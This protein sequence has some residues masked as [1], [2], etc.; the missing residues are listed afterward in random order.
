MAKRD[1]YEILGVEKNAGDSE[2]KSNYRKMAM[3]YHPDKNPGDAEA[4]EKF[5]EAAEA[6][7]VLSNPEKRARYDRFGH[8][9]MR[10]QDYG[11]YSNVNDIFS[12]FSDIFGGGIFDDFFGG[13]GGQRGGRRRSMAEQGSDLRIKLPLTLEEISKGVEKTIKIKRYDTCNTCN[14]TGAERGGFEKCSACN[15]AGEVRQVSRSM[16]GQFVNI[17]ACPSCNGSGQK[18]SN[19]CKAC[20]GEGRTIIEDTVQVKIPH[21]VESGNYLPLRG[22]GHAGRRGGQPGDLI[23]VVEEKEHKLFRRQGDHV[24]YHHTVSFPEASLGAEIFVPTLYGEE[25]IKVSAGTQPGTVV[26]LKGKGIPQLNGY[27]NGDQIVYLNVFVPTSLSTKEKSLI[28]EL[29]QS[30]NISVEDQPD[31][32]DKDFL[33]RIKDLFF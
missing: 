4:E 8:E 16:F 9:G 7:E 33:D 22:K 18:I 14:G 24:I 6:Y 13:G 17:S 28:K 19:P 23:V 25:K 27:N 5:K 12:A 20:G 26:R 29:Q 31:N 10:G 15:G 1:F 21:G 32:E 3:Q 2:I 30:K 11:G